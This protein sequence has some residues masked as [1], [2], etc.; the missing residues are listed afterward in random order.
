MID[1]FKHM[2]TRD[3]ASVVCTILAGVLVL[4][5]APVHAQQPD[6]KAV[7]NESCAA[8][9]NESVADSRAP[10]RESLRLQAAESA[11]QALTT[12]VMRSQASRLNPPGR[13]DGFGKQLLTQ[14]DRV[15]PARSCCVNRIRI[16]PPA[17]EGF[18]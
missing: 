11:V 1:G 3:I 14:I 5:A 15:K 16:V 6:G 18:N 8:C 9:H 13:V 4:T 2:L 7:F 12:G 17:S 10:N